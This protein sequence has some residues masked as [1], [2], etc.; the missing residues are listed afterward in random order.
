MKMK[1]WEAFRNRFVPKVRMEYIGGTD[2][3]AIL[4]MHPFKK[5]YE[6]W[7][8]KMGKIDPVD[9]T[10][11][12]AVYWGSVLE[13]IIA[14]RYVE[15]SGN[16]VRNVN[17]TLVHPKYDFMRGHIDRKLEAK[18]AGLEVKTVGLRSSHLWG[19]EYTDE[20]PTHYELQILHYIAITG[21]DYFDIAALFHGQEMRV[22]TVYRKKN[23]ERIKELEEKVNE[24]WTHHVLS[25]IPPMPGSTIEAA[26]AYPEA[27]RGEVA[28]LTPTQ[29]HLVTNAHNL[30]E[31]LSDLQAKLDT[32][33]TNIQ[34]AMG[35]AE[36]LDNSR[37]YEV[38]TWKN[39][40]RN[41][42]TFRTFRMKRRREENE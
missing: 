3:A 32:A 22:F 23:L 4:N 17:R 26:M 18:N 5:R 40:S 12:E 39:S 7:L 16:N 21:Y 30:S 36:A 9:L 14:Q 42:K 2:T 34:N 25:G 37:G 1:D 15:V 24:F 28:T 33:K 13:D 31:D 20:I 41:G 27:H 10:G 6:V 11:N 19:D 38:A 29:D 35:D 8:E